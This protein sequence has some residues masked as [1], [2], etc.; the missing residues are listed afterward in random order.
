MTP[1]WLQHLPEEWKTARLKSVVELKTDRTSEKQPEM[2]FIGLENIES[3]TGRLVTSLSKEET[4]DNVTSNGSMANYFNRGDVLFGKLRPYLA[5]A[6]LAGQPG[7]CSTE[8]LVFNPNQGL[9]GRFLLNVLLT[10]EFITQVDAETFG[11]KMP[12]ANWDTISNIQIPLPPLP[13]QCA[14]ADYLDR[15]TAKLDALIAAMQRLLDLLAEKRRALITHAVTRGLNP[16]APMRDSGVEWL[17]K[18]PAHWEVVHLKRVLLKMDYGISEF[19]ET[20]GNVAVL[21][22]GDISNGEILFDKVGFVEQVEPDLLLST[23]DLLFNRTNSLDQVGKVGLFCDYA[24]FPVSFAS[25]LVRMRCNRLMQA[26]YL[27]YLLN[28]P[29]VLTWARSEALP[30]IGQ[31]NLN[32]N[33]YSYLPTA[34]PPVVEQKQILKYLNVET[35]KIQKLNIVLIRQIELL[36]ERRAALI[37]AAVSGKINISGEACSSNT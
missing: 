26:E 6:H 13:Q 33:R 2:D 36:N 28:S 16:N 19:V 17:G 27:N 5:K 14:I 7:T 22:M 37:A 21:R 10:R 24:R 29:P 31:A 4:P 34:L 18:I 15:E 32:P 35:M 23:G 20:E 3:W 11:A 1:A 8:L 9:D 12:R 25:Y 30:A